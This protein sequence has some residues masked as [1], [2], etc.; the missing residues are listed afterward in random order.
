MCQKIG[1]KK[2]HLIILFAGIALLCHL[3]II[4]G[5]RV[6][7]KGKY[8][9]GFTEDHCYVYNCTNSTITIAN[10]FYCGSNLSQIHKTI[11][12]NINYCKTDGVTCYY[13]CPNVYS[14]LTIIEPEKYNKKGAKILVIFFSIVM[15]IM[16][17]SV[18]GL[19]IYSVFPS[20]I[21]YEKI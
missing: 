6:L 3:P 16:I 2:L 18:V 17:L 1:R 11:S 5:G 14:S 4:L 21:N 19:I 13:Q 20:K 9:Y 12:S 15:V 8:W 10:D 7:Q